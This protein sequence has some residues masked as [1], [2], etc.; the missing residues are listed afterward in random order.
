MWR[1]VVLLG[2]GLSAL[3]A[4]QGQLTLRLE[5]PDGGLF[6]EIQD[7]LEVVVTPPFDAYI[8]LLAVSPDDVIDVLVPNG[9]PGGNAHF[10]RAG[11]A[12]RFPPARA[13]FDFTIFPPAGRG[14]VVAVAV[15]QEVAVS[16]VLERVRTLVQRDGSWIRLAATTS[17]GWVLAA[18]DFRVVA[19]GEP[20]PPVLIGSSNFLPVR[21][22]A[23]LIG[24]TIHFERGQVAMRAFNHR[25]EFRPGDSQV[26][27]DG[28]PVTVAVP[29]RLIEGR[30]FIP[31]R[32]LQLFNIRVDRES[33]GIRL[34]L[35]D[36]R[37]L[38]IP[39]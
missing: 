19:E 25:I 3:A 22:L 10:V 35:P 39:F 26:M 1:R 2:M 20:L 36:G 16:Q 4:A 33:E 13:V 15:A 24:G 38:L 9:A 5:H 18:A 11:S 8:Y 32:F 23:E 7:Q 27:L 34:V 12:A 14:L 6:F 37:R 29:A 28:E 31:V 30:T 17:D 21:Q